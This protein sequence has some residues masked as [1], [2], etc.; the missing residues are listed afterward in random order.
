ML[1]FQ[2]AALLGGTVFL[3]AQGL[4]GH[5]FL[6]EVFKHLVSRCSSASNSSQSI[7]TPD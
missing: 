7:L 6:G 5:P 1:G 4:I 2:G 3:L